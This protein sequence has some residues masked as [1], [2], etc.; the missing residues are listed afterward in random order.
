MSLRTYFV[1][2]FRAYTTNGEVE[3]A[4]QAGREHARIIGGAYLRGFAEEFED[5]L[6]NSKQQLLGVEDSVQDV[7]VVAVTTDG[8]EYEEQ[9]ETKPARSTRSRKRS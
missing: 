7:Q 3:A 1:S 9:E 6:A 5:M 4:E 8:V 2:L